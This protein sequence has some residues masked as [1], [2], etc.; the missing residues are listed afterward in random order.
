MCEWS[1]CPSTCVARASCCEVAHRQALT[2]GSNLRQRAAEGAEPC[3]SSSPD[4]R[5]CA[6]CPGRPLHTGRLCSRSDLGSFAC[7]EIV[8]VHDV[9]FVGSD[10]ASVSG[11]KG[12]HRTR[13]HASAFTSKPVRPLMPV[14]PG[15]P[16]GNTFDQ[17]AMCVQ[18]SA[19]NRTSTRESPRAAQI[20]CSPRA[21]EHAPRYR[22][23]PPRWATARSRCGNPVARM[24]RARCSRYVLEGVV[25]DA[26]R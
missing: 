1:A 2:V 23:G 7:A 18:C 3:C 5:R 17:H 8:E 22:S 15:C 14:S 19:R 6:G 25:V 13:D 24:H 16:V 9:V 26:L 20:G 11:V 12:V 10:S 21:A 4:Y